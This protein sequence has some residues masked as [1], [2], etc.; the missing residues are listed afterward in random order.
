MLSQ[1]VGKA[2]APAEAAHNYIYIYIYIY[3]ERERYGFP[4]HLR[5]NTVGI[6]VGKTLW[7]KKKRKYI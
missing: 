6:S 4:V 3:R 5:S 7:V 1:R 2:R